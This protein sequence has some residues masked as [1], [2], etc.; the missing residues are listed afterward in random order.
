[1]RK[2][3]KER[4]RIKKLLSQE[5]TM[6]PA[7]FANLR[8]SLLPLM[9]EDTYKVMDDVVAHIE[10]SGSRT[11]VQPQAGGDNV[12]EIEKEKAASTSEL[13]CDRVSGYCPPCFELA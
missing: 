13:V 10:A 9:H 6:V 1:M 12:M 2:V 11:K 8:K 4:A 3:M 5:E 7:L